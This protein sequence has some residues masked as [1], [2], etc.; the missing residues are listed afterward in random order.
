ME[1]SVLETMI[2][3]HLEEKVN[4]TVSVEEK[5]APCSRR[6]LILQAAAADDD[7]DLKIDGSPASRTAAF[8]NP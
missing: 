4:G 3:L 1:R 7:D 5:P 8:L 2:P 6:S